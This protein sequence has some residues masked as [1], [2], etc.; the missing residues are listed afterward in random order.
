MNILNDIVLVLFSSCYVFMVSLIS[1]AS[2]I[3][4]KYMHDVRLSHL[5]KDEPQLA[6]QS[7]RQFTQRDTHNQNVCIVM[8]RAGDG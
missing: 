8:M 2:Y 3:I 1:F 7:T 4:T 6:R 5:N